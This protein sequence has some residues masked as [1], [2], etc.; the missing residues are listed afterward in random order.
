MTWCPECR[1]RWPEQTEI[2]PDC[3]GLTESN[4]PKDAVCDGN[5]STCSL[6]CEEEDEACTGN[7]DQ[8]IWPSDDDGNPIPPVRLMTVTGNQID[9][10]LAVTQLRSFGVPVVGSFTPDAA[11]SKLILGFAGSGMDIL[12][13]ETMAELARELMKPVEPEETE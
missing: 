4:V 5:C 13:P 2:C 8:G 11:L 9:Y 6:N 10:Q 1:K 7:C 3:G 12:V